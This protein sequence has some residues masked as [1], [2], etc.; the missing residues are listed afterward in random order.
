METRTLHTASLPESCS[1]TSLRWPKL[2]CPGLELPAASSTLPHQLA[3]TVSNRHGHRPI[4]A[5]QFL[6]WGPS[7]VMC[8]QP[9]LAMAVCIWCVHTCVQVH[10]LDP[11]HTW[12]ATRGCPVSSLSLYTYSFEIWSLRNLEPGWRPVYFR[13]KARV[14]EEHTTAWILGSELRTSPTGPPLQHLL[15]ALH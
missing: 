12:W 6:S 4:W 7:S 14:P 1:S 8:Q 2:T 5:E 11:V 10:W 13:S 3:T 15:L 9:R